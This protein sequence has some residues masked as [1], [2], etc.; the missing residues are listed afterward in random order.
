M[1]THSSPAYAK[2][3]EHTITVTPYRGRVVV[4]TPDGE[5]LVDTRNALALQEAK[6]PVVYYVPRADT[7]M[8]RL[9]KTAHSSVC[10]F[11]GTA[12][13]FTVE[14]QPAAVGENAVWSYEAPFDE[15]AGIREALAFYGNKLEVRAE[16]DA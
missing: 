6:Y 11:K 14:G 4:A 8:E 2:H 9:T 10:P 15:V 5:V 1:S 3:P 16:P 7:R 13:Y 12:S